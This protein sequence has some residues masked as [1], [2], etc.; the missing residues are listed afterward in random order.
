MKPQKT[1]Y[2]SILR[3]CPS[4][5]LGER[6]NIGVFYLFPD[7]QKADIIFPSTLARLS[8]LFPTVKIH[9]IKKYLHELEAITKS[10]KLNPSTL[11]DLTAQNVIE[12]HFGMPN[13]TSIFF[14]VPTLGLYHNTALVKKEDYEFYF[15]PYYNKTK[16]TPHDEPYLR[17]LFEKKLTLNKFN[18]DFL[19]KHHVIKAKRGEIKFEYMWKNGLCRLV[20]PLSFDLT[21]AASIQNKSHL[22][23]G[24]LSQIKETIE[25]IYHIDF[26]VAKPQKKENL[27]KYEE[28]ID[29]LKDAGENI[30]NIID[31]I[32][33][34][35]Y[36][37]KVVEK[38]HL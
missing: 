16:R 4:Y 36:A 11:F 3:Y 2:Y 27:K 6:V 18:K 15:K 38:A 12:E 29:T 17:S 7:E 10:I 31:E 8:D 19:T 21:D 23:F 22:W 34:E 5:A 30:F 9:D 35:E 25:G 24:K 26:L 14:D 37:S 33:I 1:Y 28:A 32:D 20:Q 13:A